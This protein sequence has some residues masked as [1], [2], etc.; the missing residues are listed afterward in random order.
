MNINK[1]ILIYKLH[2]IICVNTIILVA[3]LALSFVE[4][5][6]GQEQ[7]VMPGPIQAEVVRVIDGDTLLVRARIWPGQTVETK[8]R[9]DGV[10]TPEKRGKCVQEK[11]LAAEATAFMETFVQATPISL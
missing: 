3:L 5:R 10:N 6:A 2:K 8:V 4:S 7:G 9:L 11:E 1:H